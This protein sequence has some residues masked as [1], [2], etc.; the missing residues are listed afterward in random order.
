MNVKYGIFVSMLLVM[1]A[2]CLAKYYTIK[3]EREL[4]QKIKEFA[5]AFVA[6]A[7]DDDTGKYVK[8]VMKDLSA[9]DDFNEESGNEAKVGI[10]FVAVTDPKLQTIAQ[11]LG[12]KNLPFFVLYDGGK[13][14]RSAENPG[15][16]KVRG[17][18]KFIEDKVGNDFYVPELDDEED[19]YKLVERK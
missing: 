1:S 4:N 7:Q 18:K 6:F 15:P 17:F 2:N 11:K 12:Y 9:S 13:V 10:L 5:I 8:K 3:T 16:Y 14:V 19:E